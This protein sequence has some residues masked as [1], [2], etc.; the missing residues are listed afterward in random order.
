MHFDIAE[1]F[2]GPPDSRSYMLFNNLVR[3]N[4]NR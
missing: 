4:Q 2:L 3:F 1:T